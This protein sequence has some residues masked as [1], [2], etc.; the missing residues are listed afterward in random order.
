M[1]NN[2][3]LIGPIRSGKSTIGKILSEKLNLPQISI[4]AIRLDYYREIGY[5]E[6]FADSIREEFGFWALY[7]YWKEFECYSVER[8]IEENENSIIDF[9][10]GH[11]VYE[12]SNHFNRVKTRLEGNIV[13]LL[14]PCVDINESYEILCERLEVRRDQMTINLHFLKN[15]SNKKLAD[16]TVYT[17]DKTPDETSEEIVLFIKSIQV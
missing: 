9:G 7:F 17:K 5:D 6:K 3:V 10:A 16:F 13:I 1:K 4:D 2:I 11:S 15:E 8:I 12:N 14:Q